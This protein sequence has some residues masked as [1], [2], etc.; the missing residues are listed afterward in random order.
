MILIKLK[1]NLAIRADKHQYMLC[2]LKKGGDVNNADS[3]NPF[4]FFPRLDYLIDD[5]VEEQL[6]LSTASTLEQLLENQ[7][8]IKKEI[9]EAITNNEN[10]ILNNPDKKTKKKL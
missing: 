4:Y 8:K 3:W 6:H 5:L 1:N 7:E 2:K 10:W 9:T